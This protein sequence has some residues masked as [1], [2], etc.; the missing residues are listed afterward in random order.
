MPQF[1][2]VASRPPSSALANSGLRVLR[3]QIEAPTSLVCRFRST[4]TYVPTATKC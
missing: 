3:P 4:L 2:E 1:V